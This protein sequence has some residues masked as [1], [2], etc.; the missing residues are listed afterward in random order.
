[1]VF[2]RGDVYF[3]R[4]PLRSGGSVK[5][6]TASTD[7][8]TAKRIEAMVL[9]LASRHEWKLLDA[10]TGGDRRTL[11]GET[12]R[13]AR[14]EDTLP[15]AQVF[16]AHVRNE[17]EG[18]KARLSDEDLAEHIE[19]WQKWLSSRLGNSETVSHYHTHVRTFIPEGKPFPRS[20]LTLRRIAEWLDG[21]TVSSPTRRKYRA[22]LASFAKYLTSIGVLSINPVREVDPPKVGKPRDKFLEHAQILEL[23]L[24][25]PEPF[26]SLEALIHG[27]RMEVSA[28][29]A[30]RRSD[31]DTL[32]KAVRARDTKTEARDRTCV[33]S[34]WAWP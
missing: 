6:T 32:S 20:E 17:L 1:M 26:R 13:V 10:V 24:K 21:L 31:V 9:E 19:A 34:E 8:H 27:T 11:D 16:A 29:L 28:A 2:K 25:L 12:G 23:L 15:L 7:R 18:L 4:V 30:V 5:K 33:V 22:A 3:V 14:T